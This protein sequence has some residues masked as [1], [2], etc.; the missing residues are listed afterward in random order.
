ML[1]DLQVEYLF[2]RKWNHRIVSSSWLDIGG[3]YTNDGVALKN[4]MMDLCL[5]P[6]ALSATKIVN[7][8]SRVATQ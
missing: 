2:L 4:V 6:Q 7:G 3:V 5:G 8:S 1:K